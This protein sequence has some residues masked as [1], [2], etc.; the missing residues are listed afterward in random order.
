MLAVIADGMGGHQGGDFASST[1]IRIIG[2]EFTKLKA[3]SFQ[4]REE[5]IEW[6]KETVL[7]VNRYLYNYANK[8][9]EL[10]GMGTTLEAVLIKDRSCFG[11]HIGDSRVYKITEEAIAQITTDHSYVKVLVDSGEIT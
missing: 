11:A 9:Q 10:E 4:E 6:L 7:Y 2:E 1:A 5:W 3:S 8:N